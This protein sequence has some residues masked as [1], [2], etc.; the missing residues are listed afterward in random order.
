MN[1]QIKSF[2]EWQSVLT[3]MYYK[4]KL[5]HYWQTNVNISIYNKD[6]ILFD[7]V[8]AAELSNYYWVYVII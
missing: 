6:Y 7:V 5:T 2:C 8:I 4:H 3:S 1:K